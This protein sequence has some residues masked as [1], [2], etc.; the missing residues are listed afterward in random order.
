MTS[1]E[2][3]TFFTTG[4]ARATVWTTQRR[5]VAGPMWSMY[6]SALRMMSVLNMLDLLRSALRSRSHRNGAPEELDAVRVRVRLA[7]ERVER[8]PEPADADELERR[9]RKPVQHVELRRRTA[10]F[11]RDACA[12]L[13]ASVASARG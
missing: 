13:S 5:N 1:T 6:G 4:Q 10:Y 9:A 11:A 2:R 8:V 3:M 12:E 7:V